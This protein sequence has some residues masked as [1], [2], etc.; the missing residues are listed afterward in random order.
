M[1]VASLESYSSYVREVDGECVFV[2]ISNNFLFAGSRSGEVA[3][4]DISNGM[5]LW[6]LNFEGP[7]S[8]S[9][10][11]GGLFFFTESDFIHAIRTDSGELVWSVKLEGSSDLVR[12]CNG[13]VWV[14]TSVYNFEIQDYSEG[15][16]WQI[17]FGGV[18]LNKWE[19]MGRSWSLAVQENS[20]ILG[21]SRPKSGYAIVSESG[22]EYPELEH[23][24]PVTTGTEGGGCPVILGH[25]NGMVS[26]IIDHRVE[27]VA[28]IES[29]IRAIDYSDGWVAGTESGVVS[30]SE[31]FGSWAINLDGVID[32]ICFGPSLGD[33]KGVW[34]PTWSDENSVISLI[35]T[36]NGSVELGISHQ[37]RIVS[38]FGNEEVICF[39][40]SSG[41]VCVV[42]GNVVRRR[43]S[44]PAEEMTE[45][46]RSSELRRKI[47]ALRGG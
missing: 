16:V 24:H 18:V 15:A 3:C 44:M 30:A 29:S 42:E 1:T 6:R 26:E 2:R 32:V 7:C 12:V 31:F 13:C 45:G 17:D 36:K 33:S 11:D 22:L 19:T 34:I 47:R 20:L 37:S 4:W 21:L 25:S 5:E 14:T 41:C 27:S 10:S 35:D 9:D 8:N 40:D 39:G 46:D 23:L 43:F 28:Q 38:A